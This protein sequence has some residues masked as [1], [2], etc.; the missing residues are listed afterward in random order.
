MVE[1]L[2]FVKSYEF[3]GFLVSKILDAPFTDTAV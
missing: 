3:G 1:L 2:G